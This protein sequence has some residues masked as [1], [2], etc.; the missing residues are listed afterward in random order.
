MKRVNI[1]KTLSLAIAILT[2]TLSYAQGIKDLRFNEILIKNK[3]GLLDE[4]G[5]RYGWIE[6]RNT[7]HAAVD[8][9]GCKLV[10]IERDGTKK[11]SIFP[12]GAADTKIEPLGYILVSLNPN[13]SAPLTT[14]FTMENA[15]ELYLYD[16]SGKGQYL[17]MVSVDIS[18]IKDDVSLSRPVANANAASDRRKENDPLRRETSLEIIGENT[19]GYAN[20]SASS[21][22]RSEMILEVDENGFGLTIIAMMVVFSALTMLF[23]VFREV[24]RFMQMVERR[25]KAALNPQAK[26]SKSSTPV[27]DELN[28]EKLAVIG[29][30][31][32]MYMMEMEEIENN[33]LTINRTTK[34]YSPW[35]SKIHG[36]TRLPEIKKR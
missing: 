4:N 31:V 23:L 11:E 36:L 33:V 12:R 15:K 28:G 21:K 5:N 3:T 14:N 6:F 17:D 8:L 10:M 29:L 18:M 13:S 22:S 27:A 2:T 1:I 19:P 25:K 9:S 32:K 35:S 34:A 7:G 26:V 16:A 30:A 20:Y 24:G